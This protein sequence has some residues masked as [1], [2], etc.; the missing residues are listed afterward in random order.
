MAG[1]STSQKP[2]DAIR[3]WRRQGDKQTGRQGE[4]NRRFFLLV[5][6]SLRFLVGAR[7]HT[8]VLAIVAGRRV[9]GA[10]VDLAG[11]SADAPG[12][13]RLR[14]MAWRSNRRLDFIVLALLAGAFAAVL[15]GANWRAGRHRLACG[16]TDFGSAASVLRG[17]VRPCFPSGSRPA[18]AVSQ[19]PQSGQ[20][21][22]AGQRRDYL[23]R[24]FKV[25]SSRS[26]R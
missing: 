15:A 6:L 9:V 23:I 26:G 7:R 17:G 8:N 11:K 20:H 16:R 13:C 4:S 12:P 14:T 18:Y 19:T 1:Q 25:D 22:D 21:H 3:A 2:R 24:L 10:P 5:S